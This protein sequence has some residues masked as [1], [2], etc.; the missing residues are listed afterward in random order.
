MTHPTAHAATGCIRIPRPIRDG[1][2]SAASH[3][4]ESTGNTV[5]RSDAHRWALVRS[6]MHFVVAFLLQV[7]ARGL[8]TWHL[9]APNGGPDLPGIEGNP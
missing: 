7:I 9:R 4:I 6:P 3:R 1:S 5:L 8:L 2:H